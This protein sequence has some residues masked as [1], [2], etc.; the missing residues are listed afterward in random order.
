MT[1][2]RTAFR[3]RH[4]A[5]LS[6]ALKD[7][8]GE[9][10]DAQAV[11]RLERR[12]AT[13]L[14]L[15]SAASTESRTPSWLVGLSAAAGITVIALALHHGSTREL[16]VQESSARA[17]ATTVNISTL[18]I[19]SRLGVG[20]RELARQAAFDELQRSIRR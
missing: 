4:D 17:A 5:L 8:A 19:A 20:E 6:A 12:L 7:W 18:E 3:P 11:A 1:W 16:E 15:P 2:L 9:D 14:A 13:V 10:G